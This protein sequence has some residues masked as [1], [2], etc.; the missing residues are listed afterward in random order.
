VSCERG[1]NTF[2]SVAYGERR[3]SSEE[4]LVE[5]SLI[6]LLTGFF[7]A[8]LFGFLGFLRRE[9]V[10]RRFLLEAAAITAIT[11]LLGLFGSIALHPIAF[12][13]VL[14]ALTMRV[15]LLVDL[16]NALARREKLTAAARIYS[17][18]TRLWPDPAGALMVRLNQGACALKEEHPEEAIP[19]FQD[20][21]E[22]ADGAH[23]GIKYRCACHYN[24]GISYWRKQMLPEA[25]R[26]LE[27]VRDL[28]PASTYA[29]R[30][31]AVLGRLRENG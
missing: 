15:R 30:A 31:E 12:L 20:V 14:Y 16:G 1:W 22:K 18:A 7:Y 3:E 4:H 2:E 28:W 23:L 27:A 24:L 10:S 11:W 17:L 6:I 21:L 5:K 26:E 8:S 19:L 13:A 29:R 25:E 9:G